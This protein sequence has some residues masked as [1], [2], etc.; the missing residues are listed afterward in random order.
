MQV[1]AKI[2]NRITGMGS[3]RARRNQ[4]LIG[5]LFA[6][7]TA[8]VLAGLIIYPVASAVRLSF[9][10]VNFY[11]N[12]QRFVGFSNYDAILH[13]ISF[14][15]VLWNTIVWAIGS[16]G[17]QFGLGL[18]AALA[19]NQHVPGVKVFRNILLLPYVVPIVALTLVW[20]WML[21]GS[22]GIIS[23]SLQQLGL[24]AHDQ[25]PLAI[26]DGA[27]VS[28]I[29]ANT[30]RGFSFVMIVYWA[31]LQGIDQEQYDAAKVDGANALRE[32]WHI[33]LPNLRNATIVLLV[34][35]GIWTVTYFDLIWLITKG[36]PAGATEHWPIWIYQSAM[37]MFRFGYASALGT[38]MGITLLGLTLIY[39]RFSSD[40][41]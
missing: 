38:L 36:G 35:R 9:Y 23:Y 25:S 2:M 26:P 22:F 4:L 39:L 16:L 8:A 28:V 41:V 37:G 5:V 3:H 27:M 33:T 11:F 6:L 29:V 10:E 30:W 31:A 12:T 17:G 24:L 7:P 40:E 14:S 19:I 20:R 21:D 15:R 13:D 32:F 1:S 34:L 18:I